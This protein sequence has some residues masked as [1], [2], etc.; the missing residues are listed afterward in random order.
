M[1]VAAGF[2]AGTNMA[3]SWIN[4]YQDAKYG[5]E[6]RK[7]E[8]EE[9][10]LRL[11]QI[12]LGLDAARTAADREKQ[13]DSLSQQLTRP[14]AENYTLAAPAK[15]GLR[16]PEAAPAPAMNDGAALPAEGYSLASTPQTQPGITMPEA[17]APAV[18]TLKAAPDNRQA[19]F[20]AAP[21]RGAA[22]DILGRMA[23]LKGDTAG[24]RA[25]MG[26][27]RTM[28][29]DDVVAGKMKEYTESDEQIGAAAALLNESSP[30]ITMGDPDKNGL[31]RM[32]V[33]R[34]DRRAEFIKLSKADQAKLYA[35]GH[36]MELD[37]TRALAMI[38]DV[39]KTLADAVAA[40]RG[41]VST[42]ATN[43][44]DVAGKSATITH[45]KN[46]DARGAETQRMAREQ[47]QR[48]VAREDR[49][50][51]EKR[52]LYKLYGEYE[53]AKQSGDTAAI[54]KARRALAEAGHPTPDPSDKI[55]T[56][57]K[58]NPMGMGGTAVQRSRDGTIIVTPL[59]AAGKPGNSVTV[60]R[61]G[62]RPEPTTPTPAAIEALKKNPD[63]AGQFDAK[64]GEGAAKRA[65]SSPAA[66]PPAAPV[67]APVA[68]PKVQVQAA[69]A[70][71]AP[72]APATPADEVRAARQ[73]LQSWGLRQ[74]SADPKGFAA[75]QARL[76]A[77]EQAAELAAAA[78]LEASLKDY[79][80]QLEAMRGRF[81]PGA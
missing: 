36:V 19:T 11:E 40:D 67:A 62:A 10:E 29:V 77:A 20:N 72:A 55:E 14:N 22:E 64:Y 63:L 16:M 1:G 8:Q 13:I 27:K 52:A 54:N 61:P 53:G 60:P 34:P 80:P 76:S 73:A 74:R 28:E 68:A 49:T 45:T 9:R 43:T 26:N 75:A 41:L 30:R 42:L 39:N 18:G 71:A 44:N 56:D 4:T 17:Q 35:A 25:A 50:E 7:A 78:E 24:Y 66:A 59:D 6:K 15:A 70:T 23:L 38:G 33:V 21:T 5:D 31:V 81:R 65:L 2:N 37:P 69:P 46:A 12:R 32:S 48:A 57:F 47:F 58:P 79:G 3:R 51:A